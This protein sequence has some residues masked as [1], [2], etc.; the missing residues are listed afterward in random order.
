VAKNPVVETPSK[1]G[2][3]GPFRPTSWHGEKLCRPAGLGLSDEEAEKAERRMAAM[4]R[5][6]D[7]RSHTAGVN[8]AV[9]GALQG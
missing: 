6:P 7:D 9:R 5:S 3:S 2:D 4:I 8:I 1:P